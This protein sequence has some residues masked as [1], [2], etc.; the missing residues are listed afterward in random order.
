LLALRDVS[1]ARLLDEQRD[2]FT[3]MVVHD[4]RGPLGAMQNAL[5]LVLPRISSPEDE[6]DNT[7]L[8][9]SAAGNTSRLLRLVETLLDISKMQR[10]GLELKREPVALRALVSA[11]SGALLTTAQRSN[12]VLHSQIPDNLPLLYVDCEQVERVL[13]NLLDNA[14][15]YSPAGGEIHLNAHETEPGKWIE[16][17]ISDSGPG[18][19]PERREEVFERFRRIP[20]QQPQRGHRGHGLGLNFVKMAVE[21]HGGTIR[22]VDD[23]ELPGACFAFTLPI[24]N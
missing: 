16:V 18:I 23:S 5:Q 9:K 10:S 21:Q 13:I 11:A 14:V 2:D 7:V 20:G 12:I 17:R 19:P 6:E 15:R 1:E 3:D 4:L 22:V 8:L 24:A